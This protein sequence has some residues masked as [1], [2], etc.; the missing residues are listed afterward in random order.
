MKNKFAGIENRNSFGTGFSFNLIESKRNKLTSDAGFTYYYEN[1]TK[2][3][4]K[5]VPGATL[6]SKYTLKLTESVFISQAVSG[7]FDLVD[8]DNTEYKADTMLRI[9]L[10]KRLA[11]KVLYGIVYQ[12]TPVEGFEQSDHRFDI[13]L[14]VKF[15]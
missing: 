7:L 12:E 4:I 9:D 2:D 13:A 5:Q 14:T 3:E 1:R 10:T 11:V 8:R 6:A 15:R